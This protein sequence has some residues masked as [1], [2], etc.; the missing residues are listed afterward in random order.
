ME[1]QISA[2]VLGAVGTAGCTTATFWNL[3]AASGPASQT[4]IDPVWAWRSIWEICMQYTGE[5][6]T[7][8]QEVSIFQTPGNC[9][10]CF[11]TY[12]LN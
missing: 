7:C 1:S 5:Q 2:F 8:N 3:W 6:Y 9:K 10:N 4:F 12:R 11:F